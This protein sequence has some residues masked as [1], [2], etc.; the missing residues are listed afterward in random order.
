M[1]GGYHLAQVNIAIPKE[2]PGGPLLAEFMAALDS[3]NAVADAS[4]GFVWRLQD[5]DGNATA[6]RAFDDDTM[7]N[8]SV[9]ESLEALRAFV[10]S[11]RTHLDVMRRRREWFE[12]HVEAFQALWWIPAGHI[13]TVAE[14][15]ERLLLLRAS[16]PSPEAFT[17]RRHFPPALSGGLEAVSR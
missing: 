14:A 5:E 13:P 1:S 10:Y 8:M 9:W 16:G 6:I 12:D 15:E 3:V 2:P 4:P 11:S 7:V 17:F